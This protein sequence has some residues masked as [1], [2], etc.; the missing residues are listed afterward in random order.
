VRRTEPGRH[1]RGEEDRLEAAVPER[2]A[3][4]LP[5]DPVGAACGSIPPRRL[6]RCRQARLRPRWRRNS[7]VLVDHPEALW[8]PGRP[9][10]QEGL[11]AFW[12]PEDL[13]AFW[14]PEDLEGRED[15]L[16]FLHLVDRAGRL[17]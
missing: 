4:G 3:V 13:E 16:A 2:R 5:E 10:D 8:H 9:E 6:R 17:V 14:L 7:P 15:R 1:I 11:E 12:L